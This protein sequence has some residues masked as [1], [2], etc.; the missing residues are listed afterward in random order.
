MSA[1]T[2]IHLDARVP[3]AYAT[4]AA[5]DLERGGFEVVRVGRARELL[6]AA[7]RRRPDAVVVSGRVGPAAWRAWSQTAALQRVPIVVLGP[8]ESSGSASDGRSAPSS[9]VTCT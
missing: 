7:R 4:D 3:N 6:D 8:V 2:V 9:A 1:G 5:L